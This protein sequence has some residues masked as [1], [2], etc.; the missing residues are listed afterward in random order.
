LAYAAFDSDQWPAFP[1]ARIIHSFVITPK[2]I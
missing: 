1:L 2:T